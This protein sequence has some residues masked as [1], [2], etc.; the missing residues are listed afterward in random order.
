[1]ENN[2]KSQELE[3][4]D[5]GRSERKVLKQKK[6]KETTVTTANLTRDDRDDKKKTTFVNDST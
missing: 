1:M 6:K 2:R 5:R 4:V 3:T